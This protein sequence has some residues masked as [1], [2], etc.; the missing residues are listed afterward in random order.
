MTNYLV[1][2]QILPNLKNLVRFLET[3]LEDDFLAIFWATR[4]IL[5]VIVFPGAVFGDRSRRR[6]LAIFVAKK[7]SDYYG[8]YKKYWRI[9]L[10]FSVKIHRFVILIDCQKMRISIKFVNYDLLLVGQLS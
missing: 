8:F 2:H 9:F 5:M 3:N 4:Q 6:F 7:S 10:D 1:K